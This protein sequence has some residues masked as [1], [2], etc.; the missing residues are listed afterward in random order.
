MLKF[1]RRNASATWVKV[2]FG[3]LAAVFIYWGVGFGLRGTSRYTAVARVNGKPITD[4]DLQRGEENLRN[5]YRTLYGDQFRPE[6]L[7][8]I[9][10]RSQALDRLIRTELMVQEAQRL[11]LQATDAEV[12]EFIAKMD[13]F[14]RDGRFDRDFYIRVLRANRLTPAEFEDNVRRD[15]LVNK[16]QDIVLAGVQASEDDLKR[17]FR[18]EQEKV[19]LAFVEFDAAKLSDEITVSKEEVAQFYEQHRESFRE[20]ERVR[21][22]FIA[23]EENAFKP[24]AEVSDEQIR[25]YYESHESEFQRP[26]RVHARHILFRVEPNA[27]AEQ[28]EAIRKRAAEVLEKAR[29]GE[30]FAELARTYSEDPGS[31]P[32]GGDL[33]FF[34][35]GQMVPAFDAVAFSLPPGTIS[36]LVQTNFGFHIVKVEEKQEASTQPLDE[37]RETIRTKLQNTKARELAQQQANSDRT[38]AANGEPL[39]AIA[40]ASGLTLRTPAPFAEHDTIEGLGSNHPLSRAAF[41]VN[42]GEIGPV[43]NAPG[44]FVVFKVLE[45]IPS[46]IPDLAEIEDKVAEKS[47]LAKARQLARQKAESFLEEAKKSN[48]RSVAEAQRVEVEETPA[49]GRDGAFIPRIGDSQELKQ[50]AF[51]LTPEAPLVPRAFPVG[52]SF[53]VAA[54]LDRVEPTDEEF[55]ARKD[56][57][58]QQTMAQR[59]AYVLEEFV[60]SLQAK[61]KI[62]L[63]PIQVAAAPG[64]TRR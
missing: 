47:K 59:R 29:K 30:D 40:K 33:G 39:E 26:E 2:L 27:T 35:R 49:F 56:Q 31:G 17:R 9:D 50:A 38:R 19:R 37:V 55:A 34:P 12:R 16:L 28:K 4:K 64:A 14:Q 20:P 21:V 24:R 48:L 53:V 6:L 22:E 13:S 43:V 18:Y 60:N 57:L 1:I 52:D 51:D 23:Y 63:S 46:K 5:F 45:R 42:A 61:A 41:Q 8:G 36:D 3:V 62:E 7:Q 11:G 44:E 10:I 58:A 15:I 54:L 32:Q 25:A